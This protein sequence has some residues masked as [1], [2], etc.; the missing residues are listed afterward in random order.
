MSVYN[1]LST[2]EKCLESIFLQSYK[3]WHMYIIDD[4]CNDGSEILLNNIK[5]KRVTLLKNE[6]N[7]GLAYSLNK[8]ISL[9]DGELIAR[10]DSDDIQHIDR[11]EN[12]VLFMKENP[13]VD[14]LCTAAYL[15]NSKV[16]KKQL[17]QQHIKKFL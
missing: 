16:V 15:K 10:V 3:N 6:A 14:L 8:A 11:L 13:K 9:C 2:L 1:S 5:D 12:Q 4:A 17:C 7:R